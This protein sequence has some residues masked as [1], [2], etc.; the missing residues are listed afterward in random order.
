M[1]KTKKLL[2]AA[3]MIA[4][5]APAL[6]QSDGPSSLSYSSEEVISW[7][8]GSLEVISKDFTLGNKIIPYIWHDNSITLYD[9]DFNEIRSFEPPQ[10]EKE[11]TIEYKAQTTEAPLTLKSIRNNYA[12][13][14]NLPAVNISSSEQLK[15]Y[16]E[17]NL[18]Y[19]GLKVFTHPEGLYAVNFSDNLV[20]YTKNLD[21]DNALVEAYIHDYFFY[22][23]T[24]SM[25]YRS[26]FATGVFT[27]DR[28]S[29][30]WIDDPVEQPY[31]Y[32]KDSYYRNCDY[33]DYD[34]GTTSYLS[35]SQ[36]LFNDDDKLELLLRTYKEVEVSPEYYNVNIKSKVEGTDRVILSGYYMDRTFKNITQIVNETGKEI[37][38]FDG[39][40]YEVFRMDGKLYTSI[41]NSDS[42]Y[43]RVYL[44]DNTVA[45]GIREVACVKSQ[46][47]Q[48]KS[49]R[50]SGIQALK[51]D[52]GVIIRD[53]K[54]FIKR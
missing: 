45:N 3:A 34:T 13:S 8:S 46:N 4:V 14:L 48:G 15:T 35:I 29:L 37:A 44:I 49:Y 16:L 22:N 6:A 26:E 38:T 24:D 10:L 50:L 17:E 11:F 41:Y 39:S 54:K 5:A 7:P 19:Q 40:L 28:E 2:A 9:T 43:R 27:F 30:T 36:N 18:G 53:G 12:S 20:D 1:K 32:T 47:A 31:S 52:K 51:S 33:Y 23:P 25:I 42:G 21:W